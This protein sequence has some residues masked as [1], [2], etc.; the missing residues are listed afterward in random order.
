MVFGWF[1]DRAAQEFARRLAKE[2]QTRVPPAVL[3]KS[4]DP[5]DTTARALQ[6]VSAR[7]REFARENK[8][9][10]VRQVSL[11]RTLQG[12]LSALGYGGDFIKEITVTLARS[13]REKQ[14]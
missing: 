6:H 8:V 1:E 2:L 3:G 5:N 9:G 4:K 13:M 10:I 11:S 7:G 12:E 14:K